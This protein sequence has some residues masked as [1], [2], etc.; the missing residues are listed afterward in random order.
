MDNTNQEPSEKRQWGKKTAI[1][2][3]GHVFGRLTVI[4]LA[5]FSTRKRKWKC[6]CECNEVCE[7]KASLL[8]SGK[9]T[10]CGKCSRAHDAENATLTCR[11]HCAKGKAKEREL[12][13][14][15]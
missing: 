13:W 15:L 4:G 8:I 5:D 7:V 6:R 11:F 10:S 3:T 14:E 1:D 2:Y 9:R 12:T